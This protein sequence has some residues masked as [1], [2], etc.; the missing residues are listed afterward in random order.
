MGAFGYNEK[1]YNYRYGVLITETFL[2]LFRQHV[3]GYFYL[4]DTLLINKIVNLRLRLN[5]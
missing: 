4:R 2:L 1:R 3:V 5:I